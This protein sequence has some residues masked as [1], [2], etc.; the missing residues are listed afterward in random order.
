MLTKEQELNILRELRK[1]GASTMKEIAREV[2]IPPSTVFDRVKKLQR[3]LVQK[4]IV[5]I[6]FPKLGYFVRS[7][8]SVGVEKHERQILKQYLMENKNINNL[9]CIN[10]GYDFLVEAIFIDIKEHEDFITDLKKAFVITK[11][12]SHII[13]SD[14]V[15]ERFFTS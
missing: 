15:R 13:I 10:N 7:H 14:V 6:D 8:F 1:D 12:D 2:K 3:E 11:I 9:Y 5:L 4:T